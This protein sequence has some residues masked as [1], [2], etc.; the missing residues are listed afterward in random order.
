MSFSHDGGK[1]YYLLTEGYNAV[2]RS[3]IHISMAS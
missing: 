1:T 3:P 2:K